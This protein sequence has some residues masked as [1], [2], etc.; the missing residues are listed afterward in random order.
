MDPALKAVLKSCLPSCLVRTVKKIFPCPNAR[1]SG[2]QGDY[3]DWQ[4]AVRASS[5]YDAEV[6]FAKV[7]DA[8]RAVRDGQALWERDSVL[9]YHEEYNF[10]LV[11]ALMGVAAR[12]RGRLHVLDFGGSLGS[13]YIQH[14]KLLHTLD[15]VRWS[16]VEQPHFVVS[17]QEEF[18]TNSLRFYLNMEACA[19]ELQPDV[20]LFSSVLQYLEK[21]YAILEEAMSIRPQLLIIDRTPFYDGVKERLVVQK[22]EAIYPAVSYPMRIMPRTLFNKCLAMGNY[23]K[24]YEFCALDGAFGDTTFMGI[25]SFRET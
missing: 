23:H 14:R 9:F 10:P 15:E 2:W 18:S 11:A 7:R 20:I 22:P 6:I 25:V 19:A 1:K 4:S 13:T 12:N 17:G 16:I 21:P 3:Q 5:G 8:A 24:L